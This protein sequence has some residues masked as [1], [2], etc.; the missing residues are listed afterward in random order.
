MPVVD[1]LRVDY[2]LKHIDAC[3]RRAES[4]LPSKAYLMPVVYQLRVD[5]RLKHIDACSRPAESRLPSKA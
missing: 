3:S 1:E 4:R 2:R 5:Y